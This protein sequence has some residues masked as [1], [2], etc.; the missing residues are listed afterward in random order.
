MVRALKNLALFFVVGSVASATAS[1]IRDWEDVIDEG[2]MDGGTPK[3]LIDER[4][5]PFEDTEAS[6]Y[7]EVIEVALPEKRQNFAARARKD[8]A[9]VPLKGKKAS[10]IKDE[11]AITGENAKN[12]KR[13]PSYVIK[14]QS[15]YH[16]QS[17]PLI[18]HDINQVTTSL[19]PMGS[20]DQ[21]D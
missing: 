13:L 19:L 17:Q 15:N 7:S 5:Q 11:T 8:L 12:K 14:N 20:F 1:P 16:Q 6:D 2:A 9:L 4:N 18:L 10:E 21:P 3:P